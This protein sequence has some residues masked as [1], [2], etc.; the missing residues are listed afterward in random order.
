V[1]KEEILAFME[2][3]LAFMDHS[4]RSNKREDN[5]YHAYNLISLKDPTE[6]SIRNLYEMLEGQVAVLSSG[7][8]SPNESIQVLSALKKSALYR[9]DQYSYMLYPNRK[10]PRF[11][12]K[13]QIP[14]HRVKDS[15]LLQKLLKAKNRQLIEQDVKGGY[16]FNGS[17]RNA[18]SVK[19][20]LQELSDAGYQDE[21]ASDTG[22]ILDT[23]EE[24]FDH[25]SFTGRSGTFFGYEG[26][27]SIYW[28]MVSKLLLAVCETYYRAID[29]EE[30]KEVK[31]QLVE[32]YYEIRAG[33]GL[34]KSPDVYGAFPTDPYSHTPGNAGVQQ[35][36]M[37][38]Q[39]KEDILSRWGELGVVVKNG[40]ILFSP[41]LLRKDEFTS[42]SHEF[43]YFDL[44]GEK[45]SIEVPTASL[46]FTY[47]QTPVIFT[48]SNENKVTLNFQ[49]G[50]SEASDGLAL[51]PE[52]SAD[53]FNRDHSI[54]S[55]Q[56]F[57]EP[58]L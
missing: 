46:A 2:V 22:F 18:E 11:T 16:H 41:V 43:L 47:C 45:K 24:M 17:F 55:I 53:I 28:H 14:A 4:I 6:I 57:L 54:K 26:L 12:E 7:F 35:P 40:T 38:G 15:V 3:S 51:S 42:R 1:S 49:N 36:G 33:I 27:G 39:V 20:A 21:V 29:L 56:V 19:A 50:I 23:F 34:N 58:S 48:M 32:F 25:Q 31:G 52:V 44:N 8:L 13:N 30:S 37:T 10:L 5:L 9:K